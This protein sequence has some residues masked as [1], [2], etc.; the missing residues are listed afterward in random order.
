M[1]RRWRPVQSGAGVGMPHTRRGDHYR[2][3][4]RGGHLP[5]LPIEFISR[6]LGQ[7]PA[8]FREQAAAIAADLMSHGPASPGYFEVLANS[9]N[10]MQD[11]ITRTRL[12]GEPPHVVLLPRLRQI[13]Q[14][15]FNRAK[16]AIA[17]GR[18]CVEQALPLIRRLV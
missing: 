1:A 5:P 8:G 6:I 2:S 11:Q 16:E 10:I 12:A 3:A 9:I 15:E 14:M 18:L 7:L 13:G 4:G 17:E